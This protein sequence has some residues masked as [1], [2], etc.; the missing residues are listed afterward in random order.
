MAMLIMALEGDGCEDRGQGGAKGAGGTKGGPTRGTEEGAANFLPH[1]RGAVS[2]P[3]FRLYRATVPRCR[4]Y[5]WLVL[6]NPLVRDHLEKD[7]ISMQRL[8]LVISSLDIFSLESKMV[9]F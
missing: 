3:G 1:G 4:D 6:L 8:Y 5:Q 2:R 7:A 9:Q